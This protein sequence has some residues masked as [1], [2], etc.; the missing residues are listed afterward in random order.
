M[1]M[2]WFPVI[3][4]AC[5]NKIVSICYHIVTDM[6]VVVIYNTHMNSVTFIVT[7]ASVFMAA[8]RRRVDVL[9]ITK[10]HK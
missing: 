1:C 10:F 7:F 3:N 2:W 6:Y 4:S 5:I 8:W 9:P